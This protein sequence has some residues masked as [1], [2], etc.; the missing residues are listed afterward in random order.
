MLLVR[1]THD[2]SFGIAC[3]GCPWSWAICARRACIW[4]CR[5]SI[6]PADEISGVAS[7]RR[8]TVPNAAFLN[9]D[10][11]LFT[12]MVFSMTRFFRHMYVPVKNLLEIEW[13][14]NA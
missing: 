12:I 7:N 10:N 3:G 14:G 5:S 11:G 4:A 1:L 13:R 8:P 6:V 9:I 2:V